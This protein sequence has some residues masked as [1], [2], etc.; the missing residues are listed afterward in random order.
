MVQDDPKLPD[1]SGKVP[2]PNGV[3][4][5]SIPSCEIASLPMIGKNRQLVTDEPVELE[6][7]PVEV[8]DCKKIT[9]HFRGIHRIYPDL[10][11]DNRRMLTCKRLDLQALG[12]Q[13]VMP[14]N[15]PDH[16]SLLD[17]N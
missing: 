17:G 15:L 9:N 2:K 10:M 14:K 11:K 4:G 12:S 7:S 16:C 5:R 8:Q 13:L 3:A 6:K 1:D